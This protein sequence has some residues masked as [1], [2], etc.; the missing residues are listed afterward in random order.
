MPLPRSQP[1]PATES[2]PLPLPSRPLPLPRAVGLSRRLAS[3]LPAAAIPL[4]SLNPAVAWPA[5]DPHRSLSQTMPYNSAM[6]ALLKCNNCAKSLSST[7]SGPPSPRVQHTSPTVAE[8]RSKAETRDTESVRAL[9]LCHELYSVTA[10][11]VCHELYS[12][13]ACP[14]GARV[15]CVLH[16]PVTLE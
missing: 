1:E 8:T 3:A 14:G 4:R 5:R 6:T 10:C 9:C 16:G 7:Y 15:N 2:R 13:T 11:P 12:V